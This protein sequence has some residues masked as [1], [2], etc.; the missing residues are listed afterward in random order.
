MS[1]REAPARYERENAGLEFDR[2]AFFSDAVYAIAMTLLVV[3]IG[4]PHVR[5]ADLGKALSGL[6]DEIISFFVGFLVLAFYWLSH[7]QM[8]AQLRAVNTRFLLGNMVYLAVVAFLPFPTAIVG[9]NG[10]VPLAFVL[11]ACSLA[12]VS[13]LEVVLY[14]VAYR[15]DLLRERPGPVRHR[16]D[17]VA[18]L[19]PGI[20]FIASLPLAWIDTTLGFFF[21]LL[22]IPAER[23]LDRFL[24]DTDDP[25]PAETA[26][27]PD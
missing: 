21:W 5:D 15:Y 3:G 14:L 11:F 9:T 8:F 20:V 1:E 4:V 12:A 27:P 18:G 26:A 25:A 13:I 19:L 7:H 24:P 6:D 10:D 22:I 16:H 23:V 2:A 17:I